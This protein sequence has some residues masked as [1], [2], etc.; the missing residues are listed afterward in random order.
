M[1]Y[2]PPL[3]ALLRALA[4]SNVSVNDNAITCIAIAIDL[5]CGDGHYTVEWSSYF[6]RN[7]WDS[8]L[9]VNQRRWR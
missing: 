3:D 4:C 8:R 9:M 7:G 5:G 2:V 1:G 6:A